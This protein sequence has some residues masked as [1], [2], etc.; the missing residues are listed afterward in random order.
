MDKVSS[1]VQKL[2]LANAQV[3]MSAILFEHKWGLG[4]YNLIFEVPKHAYS[5]HLLL[6]NSAARGQ[7]KLHSMRKTC[8]SFAARCGTPPD[9][10]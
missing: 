8:A 1:R 6:E 5:S 9:G 4:C 10:L 7:E 2:P 3:V